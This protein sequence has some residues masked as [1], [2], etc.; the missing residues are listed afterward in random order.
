MIR[1]PRDDI[2]HDTYE[3]TTTALTIGVATPTQDAIFCTD[4]PRNATR[5]DADKPTPSVVTPTVAT[6]TRFHIC[7]AAELRDALRHDIIEP[8]LS[9]AT[10]TVATT[11]SIPNQAKRSI[12]TPYN[13]ILTNWHR[14]SRQKIPHIAYMSL[15]EGTRQDADKR[16]QASQ[17]LPS[18]IRL[19][20]HDHRETTSHDTSKA[21]DIDATPTQNTKR[22]QETPLEAISHGSGKPTSSIT[23][24]TVRTPTL[25]TVFIVD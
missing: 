19:R 7:I 25:D 20:T 14:A 18:R 8:T 9:V 6:P 3:P 12:E 23:T 17:H 22:T 11:N 2:R 13:T 1:D 10:S 16:R 4:E 24:P 5:H 15:V 21:T